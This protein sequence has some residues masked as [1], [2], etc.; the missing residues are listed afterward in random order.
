MEINLGYPD[1]NI[2]QADG[3]NLAK[4]DNNPVQAV[5]NVE[6]NLIPTLPPNP[7][8]ELFAFP[9]LIINQ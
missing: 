8:N 5:H 6:E 7:I 3:Q 9:F 2:V 1:N 4:P